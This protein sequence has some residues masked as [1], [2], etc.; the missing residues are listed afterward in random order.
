MQ[1]QLQSH[2]DLQVKHRLNSFPHRLY[3]SNLEAT[4]LCFTV[5]RSNAGT[6]TI[7]PHSQRLPDNISFQVAFISFVSEFLMTGV[8]LLDISGDYVQSFPSSRERTK[9]MGV[10]QYYQ[11]FFLIISCLPISLYWLMSI[12]ES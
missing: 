11:H 6:W 9:G 1:S 12:N 3:F 8:T 5:Y 2:G 4:S 10:F 7:C